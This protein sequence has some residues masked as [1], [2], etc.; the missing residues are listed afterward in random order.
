M[1]WKMY[2]KNENTT[3]GRG[4]KWIPDGSFELSDQG[5]MPFKLFPFLENIC[6]FEKQV[7][8]YGL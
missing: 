7:G 8:R 3:N 6:V 5:K 1:L 2:D 4:Q